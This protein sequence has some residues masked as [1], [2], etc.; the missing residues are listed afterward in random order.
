MARS[1]SVREYAV[2]AC[3]H[4]RREGSGWGESQLRTTPVQVGEG[5]G[6]E[7]QVVA[8][9]RLDPSDVWK[10]DCLWLCFVSACASTVA[11][12]G[13]GSRSLSPTFPFLLFVFFDMPPGTPRSPSL[14]SAAASDVYK[15]QVYTGRT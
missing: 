4:A 1:W 11:L 15:G 7:R 3:V 6:E 13:A 14:F 10:R 2:C 5:G 9:G 12:F 8:V